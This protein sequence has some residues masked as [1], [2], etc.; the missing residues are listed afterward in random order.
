MRKGLI[1]GLVLLIS[2]FCSVF[3]QDMS[4]IE[5]KAGFDKTKNARIEVPADI[6]TSLYFMI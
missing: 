2:G 4:F 3:A 1:V 6:F 5:S